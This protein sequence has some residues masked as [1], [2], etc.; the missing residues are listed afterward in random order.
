MNNVFNKFNGKIS[1]NNNHT[2]N[3]EILINV[4]N[5]FQITINNYLIINNIMF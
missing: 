4:T 3:F 2:E 5:L 1:L